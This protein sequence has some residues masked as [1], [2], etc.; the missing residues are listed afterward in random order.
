[1]SSSLIPRHDILLMMSW[2]I[3]MREY[4]IL[5]YMINSNIDDNM[6]WCMVSSDCMI[7]C[8]MSRLSNLTTLRKVQPLFIWKLSLT[9]QA[10]HMP[11]LQLS[12]QGAGDQGGVRAG[13][14]LRGADCGGCFSGCGCGVSHRRCGGALS[15]PPR[16]SQ[17]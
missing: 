4:R 8:D 9:T 11:R 16:V 1:M 2:Y 15:P 5:S 3:R 10:N 14:Y 12:L 7:S 6:R 13:R 17:G